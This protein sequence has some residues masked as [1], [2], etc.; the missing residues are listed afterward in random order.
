MNISRKAVLLLVSFL[1]SSL[2]AFAYPMFLERFQ[3]DPYRRVEVDGCM[4]C[5]MSAAGG[6]ER[7]AFGLAFAG[8]GTMITPML[9]E[10]FPDRFAYPVS[11]VSE[12]MVVHFSDPMNQQVVVESGGTKM[13]VNVAERT[14]DG[15]AAIAPGQPAS[16]GGAAPAAAP[17]SATARRPGAP[18]V[19]AFAREGAFFG[20]QIV[21]LP[22]GKP[23]PAG[24]VD[25]Q[26]SHR[27]QQHVCFELHD[28]NCPPG[29]IGASG[30]FGFDGSAVVSYGARVGL[31][32]RITVGA[33]RSNRGPQAIEVNS[34][35]H[36]TRQSPSVPVTFAVRAGLEGKRN[37]SERF[38]PII[39][40]IVTHTIADRVSLA[41]VPT[42][43]FNTRNEKSGLPPEFLFGADH[44]HTISLGLGT[45]V[46]FLRST[47]VVGEYIPRLY[48]FRGEFKDRPGASIGMQFSTF[49]HTF[50]LLI[51]RQEAMTA[52]QYAV[53]GT[54]TFRVGF[55]IYRK[56]R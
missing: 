15:R 17:A 42:F 23:V 38:S 25:F 5:H 22:N 10:Q 7:N 31:T 37:F 19:D 47:S 40:P 51:S 50:E 3:M 36:L 46:R 14:V 12:M 2:P 28:A 49:R 21:N 32:D 34:M 55:N 24:G 53:Q 33:T 11:R 48:G 54:D 16:G 1:F 43:A 8:A 29:S 39:Q 41:V 18:L 35:F 56:V 6:D 45:G 52:A 20:M 27:F 44:N 9:R 30:L 13:L 4:T 26:I